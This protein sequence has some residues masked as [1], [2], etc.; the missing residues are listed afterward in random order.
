MTTRL[1][2]NA[3]TNQASTENL[4]S[5]PDFSLSL[6]DRRA[7]MVCS[8]LQGQLA[9]G[10]TLW[11]QVEALLNE[12]TTPW[13]MKAAITRAVEWRR[14]SQTI[15]ELAWLL[16]LTDTQIDDLFVLAMSIEV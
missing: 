3:T 14:D 15:D 9:L 16:G 12:P 11:T 8:P 2:I 1:Q 13:A 7:A 10:E 6:A 5:I 4:P